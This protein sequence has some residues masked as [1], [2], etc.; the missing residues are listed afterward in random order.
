MALQSDVGK[1]SW[2]VLDGKRWRGLVGLDCWGL[3]VWVF[4]HCL[5][6]W[7]RRDTPPGG[8]LRTIHIIMVVAKESENQVKMYLIGINR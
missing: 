3:A 7:T 5:F 8:R 6:C 2:V 4:Y 1:L